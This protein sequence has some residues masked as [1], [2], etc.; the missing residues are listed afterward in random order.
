MPEMIDLRS[1]TVTLPTPEMRQAMAGAALGDDCYGEDP[2]VNRLQDLAAGLLDKEA[3]LLVSSGTMGNL[4]G[5]L[6]HS[7]RGDRVIAGEQ[8]HI[9][10]GERDGVTLVGNLVL[11]TIPD[12]HG[13]LVLDGL[14]HALATPTPGGV[15]LSVVALENTHNRC[16]GTPLTG[17]TISAYGELAR[18][19]G[20]A[21]HVD[22]ARIFNAAV[23]LDQDVRHLAAG[24][25]SVTFCLSKGLAAPAGSVLCGSSAYI[26]RARRWRKLLGGAMRQ[27]GVLAA[28][29]I[30]AL[31]TM[32]HRLADD[33][34]HAQLLAC[35]LA[36]LPGLAI[37]PDLVRTN[38]LFLE[39]SHPRLDAPG[40][41]AAMRAEGVWFHAMG[42]Q[43]ARMVT[44][45]GISRSDIDQTLI[46][47]ARV[48]SAA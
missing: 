27:S 17:E 3:A 36:D 45:H 40:F 44:H 47:A 9:G 11:Q 21:L 22:G 43:R 30:V 37:D 46:V 14:K 48:L 20:A 41:S 1:D 25:D 18:G 10:L 24:A 42:S 4:V 6:A 26:E 13:V 32:R 35:G 15:R 38:L 2:T 33:H 28:A 19:S 5:L 12:P 16:N 29:G 34:H 8:S 7:A 39:V 23:A 31:E